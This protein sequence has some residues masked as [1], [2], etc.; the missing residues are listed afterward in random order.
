MAIALRESQLWLRSLT[1]KA[2]REWV[3]GSKLLSSKHKEEIKK[4]YKRGYKQDYQPYEKP[5]YWAAFCAT[6]Q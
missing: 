6:G 5:L 2:L 3:E 4:Q 1:V